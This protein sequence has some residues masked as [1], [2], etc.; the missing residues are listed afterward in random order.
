MATKPLP[1]IPDAPAF[2]PGAKL[3][4]VQGG[5]EYKIPVAALP[6]S[7][8]DVTAFGADPT[9][10]VECSAEIQ[11]A[12]NACAAAGGGTV[13]LP[14][15]QYLTGTPLTVPSG[16]RLLGDSATIKSALVT[17]GAKISIIGS[18]VV[19]EGLIL[20]GAKT[21]TSG[22]GFFEFGLIDIV[23]DNVAPF[24]RIIVQRCTIRRSDGCGIRVVGNIDGLLV[25]ENK[26]S[27]NFIDI[28]AEKATSHIFK[29]VA[30]RSNDFAA[31]WATGTFSAAVKMKGDVDSGIFAT[32]VDVS[33]NIIRNSAEMGI[34]LFGGFRDS[35]VVN[36]QIVGPIF[37]ISINNGRN[38]T[39][40]LNKVF[41]C[42]YA[43]IEIA[44]NSTH[45]LTTANTVDQYTS[46]TT[47]GGDAGIITSGT[48]GCADNI[49][50]G[51]YVRGSNKGIDCQNTLRATL[52]GN[53]VEDCDV[54]LN[55]KKSSYVTAEANH[56]Y[57][58]SG[59]PPTEFH[60]F[61]DF[62][63]ADS[64][65]ID[66]IRNYLFGHSNNDNIITYRG[67][68]AWKL[69]NLR[70]AYNNVAA[71]SYAN[72]SFNGASVPDADRPNLQSYD[73]YTVGGG[74]LI[75][76]G[77][78][79][80]NWPDFTTNAAAIPPFAASIQRAGISTAGK[81]TVSAPTNASP[82][83]VKV[84]AIDFGN[85]VFLQAHFF[86][87]NSSDGDSSA[88]SV[89][90]SATPYGLGSRVTMLPNSP[91][92]GVIEEVIAN[93][94]GSGSITEV[95]LKLKASPSKVWTIDCHFSDYPQH[96]IESPTLTTVSPTWAS[97]HYR[98]TV[99]QYWR[100]QYAEF[101]GSGNIDYGTASANSI[102]TT[103]I[104]VAGAVTTGTP[105][106]SVGWGAALPT[107][108][109]LAQA[110][111]T[112]ADTVTITLR[113]VTGSDITIGTIGTRVEVHQY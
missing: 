90:I 5:A 1:L 56:L 40:A 63:N 55:I 71:A 17:D 33:D 66:I 112:A 48:V 86:A 105:T 92:T 46:G 25:I 88:I 82:R 9:G 50:T 45:C 80:A 22:S 44:E 100:F 61:V 78:Y 106:V 11:S 108:I 52:A 111:V 102:Q 51:N 99:E 36:N 113:N 21:G 37:G 39:V 27:G 2:L 20:D 76:A 84:A 94:P 38:V 3:V 54:L 85:V 67:A 35:S 26:F 18:D 96:I 31:T 41:R 104:Y 16:V 57:A 43:G 53:R 74:E 95:W 81:T 83:W 14:S 69:T 79:R 12:I 13:V 109:V 87:F 93:N 19:I 42:S 15:G 101:V 58:G 70:V 97:N 28:F 91:F 107:G 89:I 4:A 49:F 29:N 24:S 62:T 30:I 73:N 32:L 64:T 7:G 68:T 98:A 10:A 23:R 47:R 65:N 34:E 59:A 60:I 103:N 72:A 8:F 110:R 77:K 6:G 75:S